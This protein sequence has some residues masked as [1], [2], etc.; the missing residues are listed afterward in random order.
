M[1]MQRAVLVLFVT[2]LLF[3]LPAVAQ[4]SDD[5]S[6]LVDQALKL[7]GSSQGLAYALEGNAENVKTPE[8][9]PAEFVKEYKQIFRRE[10]NEKSVEAALRAS[11]LNHCNIEFFQS[12]VRDLQR[13][14]VQVVVQAEIENY[15]VPDLQGKKAKFEEEIKNK[16]PSPARLA[17]LNELDR[18][19]K[20]TESAVEIKVGILLGIFEGSQLN[21]GIQDNDVELTKASIRSKMRRQV[22]NSSLYDY[23]NLTDDQIR[24][25]LEVCKRGPLRDFYI[26]LFEYAGEVFH[27]IAVRM[28]KQLPPLIERIRSR[29][30][31]QEDSIR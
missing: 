8:E 7:S 13:P 21:M 10:L 24:A 22:L 30:N 16:P 2:V 27:D 5:C 20:N 18:T 6:A 26:R 25:Y 14:E 1:K 12:V 15:S 28:G 3:G 23:R 31:E 19:L 9:L 11:F 17:L 29:Q 4:S